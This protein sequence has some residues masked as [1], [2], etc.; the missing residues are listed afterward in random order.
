[1]K[2]K[3]YKIVPTKKQLNILKKYW[4]RYQDNYDKFWGETGELERAM[5]IE[6][7]IKDLEFFWCDG[8]CVGIGQYDRKMALIP[9]EDL[10]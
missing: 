7:K 4:K 6:T 5:N 10:E 9:R 3:Q 2:N 1:M 8:E